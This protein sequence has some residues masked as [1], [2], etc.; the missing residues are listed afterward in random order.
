MGQF[1]S[2]DSVVV[3]SDSATRDEAL[4]FLGIIAYQTGLAASAEDACRA[5]LEREKAGSTGMANGIAIPHAKGTGILAPGLIC[6]KYANPVQWAATDGQPI[7]M[8]FA[9]LIPEGIEGKAHLKNLSKIASLAA[10]PAL[11]KQLMT[12]D[13]PAQVADIVNKEIGQK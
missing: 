8:A 12:E 1:L 13:D 5:F 6:V 9:L 2:K 10:N 4:Q 11:C 7:T 3:D